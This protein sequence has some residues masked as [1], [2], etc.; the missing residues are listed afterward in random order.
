[1]SRYN[2]NS[3]I[4]HKDKKILI[5]DTG[6][7]PPPKK[8]GEPRLKLLR[9]VNIE[10]ADWKSVVL[11]LLLVIKKSFKK[12]TRLSQK[13]KYCLSCAADY[14]MLH[15]LKMAVDVSKPQMTFLFECDHSS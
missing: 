15:D 6:T 11:L 2:W 14:S 5:T 3:D 7:P 9:V 13:K 4:R 1:M 8:R 10:T 12:K